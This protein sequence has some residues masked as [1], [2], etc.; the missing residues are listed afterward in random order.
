MCGIVGVFAFNNAEEKKQAKKREAMTFLFTELLQET[1]IRGK[2][3]TGVSALFDD[4]NFVIQKGGVPAEEFISNYGDSNSNYNSFVEFCR[5]YKDPLKLLVGHCRKSSVGSNF[6]NSNNHPIRAGEIIGVH[7]GTLTNHE[8]VFKKL[9]CERDGT[10][11]SEAIMRLLQVYTKNCTEPFT[12]EMLSS[13]ACHL[14]GAFS[15]IAFNANNPYQVALMRKQRPLEII[16]IKSLKLMVIVS[17]KVFFDKAVHAFNK[18]ARLYKSGFSVIEKKDVEHVALPM[19]NVA[20]IDLTVNMDDAT[21]IEDLLDK[22]DTFKMPKFWQ[23]KVVS[24]VYGG[25][26]HN[27]NFTRTNNVGKKNE[28]VEKSASNL[29]TI[30]QTTTPTT[31][32]TKDQST[33]AG[34]IFSK[35]LNRYVDVTKADSLANVKTTIFTNNS[36]QKIEETGTVKS[37][38]T[39]NFVEVIDLTVREEV[40]PVDIDIRGVNS[41][42][43]PTKCLEA[44]VVASATVDD[45]KSTE[46]AKLAQLAAL[47]VRKFAS[48]EE[49][50]KFLQ[51]ESSLNLKALPLQALAN[52]IINKVYEGA[53]LDGL[54]CGLALNETPTNVTKT[55]RL[56]KHII[57]LFG[58]VLGLICTNRND[59]VM[60]ME[61]TIREL[62]LTELTKENMQ[63]LFSS[64]DLQ[65]N[66]G[67]I[68][69]VKIVNKQNGKKANT[70]T[71]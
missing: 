68:E 39:T 61:S 70:S 27:N 24:N 11:D 8:T 15:V 56:A 57:R 32:L 23:T 34:K 59:M 58:R 41:V 29:P 63:S 48:E 65:A 1:Q 21:K 13:V 42:K 22:E 60:P 19:D 55:V 36:V 62:N 2:D 4:G 51:A 52:R 17:E 43:E 47:S 16:I 64:G 40:K 46:Y 44:Q 12:V 26:N 25:Y 69:L 33:F 50:V 67:L 66:I 31:T 10:V 6:N 9:D 3:A 37:K 14:D 45:S 20:V 18:Y 53:Y 28:S 49:V 7:N 30:P 5:T 71:I 38:E 35:E 54:D